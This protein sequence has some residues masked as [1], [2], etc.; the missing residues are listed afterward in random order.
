MTI[1]LFL[2]LLP[3]ILVVLLICAVIV[4]I[5]IQQ[6]GINSLKA[7]LKEKEKKLASQEASLLAYKETV[8]IAKEQ[9]KNNAGTITEKNAN[10]L[11]DA[12]IIKKA[13]EKNSDEDIWKAIDS[14]FNTTPK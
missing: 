10:F 13:K 9:I 1:V 12:E 11:R 5:K 2:K 8:D 14:Y 3:Y 4:T 6:V 7:D